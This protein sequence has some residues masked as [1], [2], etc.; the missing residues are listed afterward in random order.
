MKKILSAIFVIVSAFLVYS[1]VAFAQNVC[2]TVDLGGV[3]LGFGNSNCLNSLGG[4]GWAGVTNG[5]GLPEGSILGIIQNL[6]FWLLTLFAIIGIIGFVISGIMYLTSA[7]DSSQAGKAKQAMMY[8]IYGILIGLSGF[9]I[10]K[11]V[12]SL[13]SGSSTKF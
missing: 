6:L 11:A 1:N 13:L 4:G 12:S 5:Y 2:G 10:M 3:N 8:S 9:V 7:G